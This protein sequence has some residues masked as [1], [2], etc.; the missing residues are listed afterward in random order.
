MLRIF[1]Y[2]VDMIHKIANDLDSTMFLYIYIYIYVD[3]YREKEREKRRR[4]KKKENLGF[5]GLTWLRL[6]FFCLATVLPELHNRRSGLHTDTARVRATQHLLLDSQ[7]G[8][9]KWKALA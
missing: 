3:R 4:K 6:V 8:R 9:G 2:I 7:Q 1:L 5:S